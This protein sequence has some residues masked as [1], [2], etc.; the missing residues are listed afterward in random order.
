MATTDM[1]GS[2][3]WPGM[4]STSIPS[5]IFIHPELLDF[6]VQGKSN[7]GRHIDHPAGHHSIRTNQCPPTPSPHF[8]TGWMPFLP[9][10]QHC[11]STE[12]YNRHGPKIGGCSAFFWGGETRSSSITMLLG[13]RPTFLPSGILIHSAIWPQQMGRTL[14]AVLLWGRGTW[15]PI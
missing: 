10:N 13:S 14:G 2:P 5:G 8:F 7:T 1:G 6:M 4:R 15:V 12:G 9:P 3:M 11:L